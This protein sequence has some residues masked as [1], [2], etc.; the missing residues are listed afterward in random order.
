[1][2]MNK[3]TLASANSNGTQSGLQ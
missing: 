3:S 1:M 2:Q